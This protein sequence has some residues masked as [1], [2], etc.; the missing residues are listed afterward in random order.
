MNTMPVNGLNVHRPHAAP[1]QVKFQPEEVESGSGRSCE[2][3]QL[4]TEPKQQVRSKHH[5][6]EVRARHDCQDVRARR[7]THSSSEEYRSTHNCTFGVLSKSYAREQTVSEQA[8]ANVPLSVSTRT[9][10]VPPA[11][12]EPQH[13]LS[14]SPL[15][16]TSGICIQTIAET[17]EM[18]QTSDDI[19]SIKQNILTSQGFQASPSPRS[20]FLPQSTREQRGRKFQEGENGW[21]RVGLEGGRGKSTQKSGGHSGL[22]A[23]RQR[24]CKDMGVLSSLALLVRKFKY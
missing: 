10:A 9:C 12:P 7:H 21:R 11:D 23:E 2:S 16:D 13:S 20:L 14:G 22:R 15:H 6:Q 18:K 8:G 3:Q 24:D 17:M 5:Y 1:S 19:T 4:V